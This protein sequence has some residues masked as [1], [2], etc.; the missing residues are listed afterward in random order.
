VHNFTEEELIDVMILNDPA[1][2]DA[3]YIRPNRT[4]LDQLNIKNILIQDIES[5]AKEGSHDPEVVSN[6]IFNSFR[7]RWK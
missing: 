3:R 1:S 5:Q 7:T 4:E 2:Q 6:L